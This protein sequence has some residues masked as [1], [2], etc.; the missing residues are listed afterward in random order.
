MNIQGCDQSHYKCFEINLIDQSEK[1]ILL[2]KEFRLI[3]KYFKA[4]R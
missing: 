4:S 3:K 2:I 1:R